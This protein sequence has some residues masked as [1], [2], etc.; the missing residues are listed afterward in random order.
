MELIRS[1]FLTAVHLTL[2]LASF[3]LAKTGVPVKSRGTGFPSLHPAVTFQFVVFI[4]PPS[5]MTS[6]TPG[7]LGRRSDVSR[8]G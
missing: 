7:V 3:G 8:A 1:P 2:K 4:A 6:V 5:Q